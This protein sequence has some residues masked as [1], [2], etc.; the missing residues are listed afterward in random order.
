MTRRSTRN[1]IAALAVAVGA[2]DLTLA[3]SARTR[4]RAE[5]I[6]V[7]WTYEVVLGG[8]YLLL[9]AGIVLILS[10]HGLMRGKRNAWRV[11]MIAGAW[12]I[13]GHHLKEADAAG[14]VS[15]A[16]L[17]IALLAG[18][19][20]FVARPDPVLAR[21]GWRLLATGELVVLIYGLAG[22]YFL[23]AEYRE[24]STL[25]QSL[26]DVLRLLVLLPTR[27]V[28]PVTRHGMWFVAS[29]RFAALLV[30]LIALARVVS[31]V[32][33]S[34]GTP[35]DRRAVEALLAQWGATPL[36]YF[37]LLGEK[38]WFL[39]SDGASFIGYQVVGTVAVA[40]G[41]P[42]G[43]PSSCRLVTDEFV[44]YCVR[45]GWSVAFHQVT[46]PGAEL[47]VGS[48]LKMLKIGEEAMIPVQTWSLEGA[49]YKWLR[50]ALR[51]IERAGL[52]IAELPTPLSAH[53]LE[54]LRQ[55]SDSWLA[56]GGHRERTFTLGQFDVDELNATAVL[57][58]RERTTARI[59][60][61]ANIIPSYRSRAGNFDLM[62]RRS[63]APNGAMDA[64]FV[65]LIH[66]F[67]DAGL[68]RMSLGMV[69]FVGADADTLPA[70][71]IRLLYERGERAFN[72]QGLFRFK[73]KWH[74]E[75]EPRYLVYRSDVDLPRIA[76]AVARVG[77]LPDPRSM[78]TRVR[79][80]AR[81]MPFSCALIG[82]IT[83]LM[84]VTR[85]DS[86]SHKTLLRAIGLGWHDLIRLQVW[87]LPTSQLMQTSPG[88]VWSIVALCFIA[89]PI[90]EWRAGT[91]KT[92]ILFFLCDWVSTISVL[93]G[94]EIVGSP[95]AQHP[96]I[97]D[98]GS[99]SGAWALTFLVLS[100]IHDRRRRN[101]AF[102]VAGAFLVTALV[103]HHRLFDVQHLVAAAAALVGIS[104]MARRDRRTPTTDSL[105]SDPVLVSV[106]T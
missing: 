67:R 80:I 104:V 8:R 82:V 94:T 3:A 25:L 89:A 45:S 13:V 42:I 22:L 36:A 54:Q 73:N 93:I 30:V 14:L 96:S 47:L 38:H 66:R 20:A 77:E 26:G 37:H 65:A 43:E 88:L 55:V 78:L 53:D 17:V 4:L 64:L 49:G 62:R 98:A 79:R 19:E 70:R 39:A 105:A 102:G 95:T 41:E 69:P 99:S 83:W 101:V 34:R 84:V 87:R 106:E 63:D 46:P 9:I 56:D 24:S 35:A 68:E 52:E 57:V 71:A 97:R 16:V 92:V 29:V 74:P 23:D 91:M 48:G 75:W 60:A 86:D 10:A 5:P 11:A 76:A 31:A 59:V 32:I 2:T 100:T 15:C 40:L 51:R 50:S 33:V 90:A 27:S 58:L 44:E 18:R 103:V 72:S 28:V 21:S 7:Q 61:F 1:V 81:R 85:I 6:V 12:S